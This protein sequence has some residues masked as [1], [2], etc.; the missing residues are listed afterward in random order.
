MAK[1]APTPIT[2]ERLKLRLIEE[3]DLAMT[4][5]WRNKDRVRTRFIFT[6]KL[7]PESHQKW[8][9]EYRKRSNDYL[10]VIEE[11]KTLNKPVGQISIYNI[12]RETKSAEYGRVMIGEEDALG[13]GI[14]AEASRMLIEHFKKNFQIENFHLEVKADNENAYKMYEH[15]GFERVEQSGD[16]ISMVLNVRSAALRR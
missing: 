2:S 12:D 10:Y 11:L 7:D 9:A 16:L 6:D 14:A 4:R 13:K 8:F 5:E 15:L 3:S 1:F